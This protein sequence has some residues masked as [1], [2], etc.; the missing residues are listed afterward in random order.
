MGSGEGF[1]YIWGGIIGLGAD[2]VPFVGEMPG[3]LD[4]TSGAGHHGQ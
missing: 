4:N 2:G 3:S 1:E